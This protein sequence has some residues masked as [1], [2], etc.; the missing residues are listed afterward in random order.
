[1]YFVVGLIANQFASSL[2]RFRICMSD[3]AVPDQ[4]AKLSSFKGL[5]PSE[6]WPN[7]RLPDP[8]YAGHDDQLVKGDPLRKMRL[9]QPPDAS[10]RTA[11]TQ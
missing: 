9:S 1:M 5:A 2:Q 7:R 3:K 6:P 10:D 8:V 11:P 4:I